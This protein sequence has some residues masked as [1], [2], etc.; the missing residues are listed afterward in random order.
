MT[1]VLWATLTFDRSKWS[2]EAT[3][4]REYQKWMGQLA[5]H[6]RCCVQALAG[7]DDYEQHA[8]LKIECKTEDVEKFYRRLNKFDAGKHWAHKRCDVQLWNPAIA[9]KDDSYIINKHTPA[10]FCGCANSKAPCRKGRCRFKRENN[11]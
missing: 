9:S 6:T 4:D 2:H 5:N 10:M 3:R 11:N 7:F 8:H 1:P